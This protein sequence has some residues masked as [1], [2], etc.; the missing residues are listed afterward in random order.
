MAGAKSTTSAVIG[1]RGRYRVGFFKSPGKK[2]I[3]DFG[4]PVTESAGTKYIIIDLEISGE[5]S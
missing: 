5:Y 2:F 3:T 1:G 4:E